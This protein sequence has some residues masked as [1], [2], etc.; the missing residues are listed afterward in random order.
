MTLALGLAARMVFVVEYAKHTDEF[1]A[2]VDK[3]YK[4][5]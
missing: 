5:P 4:S 2:D 1:I 3:L